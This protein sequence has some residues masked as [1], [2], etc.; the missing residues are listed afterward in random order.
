MCTFFGLCTNLPL[1]SAF[2][3]YLK[4]L[5]IDFPCGMPM[6]LTPSF[7]DLHI[8]LITLSHVV[9]VP[10]M[11]AAQS[12]AWTVFAHLNSGI[13]GSNPTWGMDVRVRLFCF[14]AVLCAGS[15]LA[16]GPSPVQ[17][18]PLCKRFRNWKSGQG[19]TKGCRAI[20]GW[21]DEWMD[22]WMVVVA[23]TCTIPKRK[24]CSEI[25]FIIIFTFRDP[26]LFPL[27]EHLLG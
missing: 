19:R 11:L 26:R 10:F 17:G 3:A 25:F 9:T 23:E 12:E 13:V 8:E 27:Y 24:T 16:T 5:V 7:K 15:G 21:V 22:G 4:I 14:H 2:K 18:V 20:D 6:K 1:A